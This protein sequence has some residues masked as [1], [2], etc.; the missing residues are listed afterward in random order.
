MASLT[1]LII[2]LENL[3]LPDPTSLALANSLYVKKTCSKLNSVIPRSPRSLMEARTARAGG[4][5]PAGT[6]GG[7]EEVGRREGQRGK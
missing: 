7:S 2:P 3:G 5:R 1:S 6:V 4:E